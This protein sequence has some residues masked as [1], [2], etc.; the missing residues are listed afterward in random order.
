M[1]LYIIIIF[2][3]INKAKIDSQNVGFLCDNNL[4]NHSVPV[5]S[6]K[7]YPAKQIRHKQI[8]LNCNLIKSSTAIEMF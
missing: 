5:S 7:Y 8:L 6:P 1:C 2:F 3:N 4:M